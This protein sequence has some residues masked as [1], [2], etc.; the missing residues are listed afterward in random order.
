PAKKIVIG[1]AFYARSWENVEAINSGLYQ[2]GKH[3]EG[4]KFKDYAT[5]YTPEHGYMYHWDDV[6]KAPIIYNAE[7]KFF[8]T[9]DDRRS[10]SEKTL[11]V[12][13]HGLGGIMFWQL[14]HDAD[15]DGLLETIYRE[16]ITP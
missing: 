14:P 4:A 8:A 13:Q 16:K 6:A 11:Y 12:K 9:F 7:K 2:P 5:T 1:A 10:V 3:V 15:G